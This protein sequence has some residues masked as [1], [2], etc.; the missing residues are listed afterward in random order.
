MEYLN[1]RPW[2]KVQIKNQ[3]NESQLKGDD[4]EEYVDNRP[5]VVETYRKE[6]AKVKIDEF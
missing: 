6:L 4:E 1:K 3:L 2:L 5:N